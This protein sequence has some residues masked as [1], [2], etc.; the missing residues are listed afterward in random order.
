MKQKKKKEINVYKIH[1]I[2][3]RKNRRKNK[4]L[5]K[6]KLLNLRTQ[7]IINNRFFPPSF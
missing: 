4:S 2:N 7:N 3:K 6:E 5:Y 1:K